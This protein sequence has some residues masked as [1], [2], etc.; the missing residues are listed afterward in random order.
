MA[1]ARAALFAALITAVAVTLLLAFR[2]ADTLELPARDLVLRTLPSRDATA[3]TVVA[4]DEPSLQKLGPWP[5]RREAIAQLVDHAAA[6]GA[7][8]A[9]LDILLADPAPGDDRLAAAL[10][11]LPS[12]AV[13]GMDVAEWRLPVPPL[14]AAAETAHGNFE[15]DHDGIARRIASTKQSRTQALTALS[16]EAASIVTAR[17]VP[18]GVSIAPMF[19]TRPRAIPIVSA[20]QLLQA[21][22]PR[23][24][25]KL[26]FLGPTA[27][28]LGDRV[29]TP[30]SAQPDPGVTVHAAAT[31]SLI[32]GDVV[33][34]V[35][36]IGSAL[37]SGAA[38]ASILLA[39]RP[40]LMSAA[41]AIVVMGGGTLLLAITGIAIPFITL[42]VTALFAIAGVETVR[43]ANALRQSHA[44]VE[45]LTEDRAQQVESKRV[46]AHELK[47]PL[48]SMRG[49]SQLLA[50]FDLNDAERRRVATLLES[51]AGKLQSMVTGLLDLER[52]STRDFESSSSVIDLGDLVAARVEFLRASSDREMDVIRA[53]GLLVRA[54]AALI[55]RV[56]D[57]LVG[58]A[59]KYTPEGSPITV[60]VR[61]EAG[62]AFIEVEDRGTGISEND[63]RRIFDRFFRGSSAAGTQGL[64]LGLSLVAE[65][66]RWHRGSASVHESA[67][68]G[69]LFRFALPLAQPV[70]RAGGM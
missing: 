10:R 52:L 30:V 20:V 49:L 28:G 17:P 6:S 58:N 64:G 22:M 70:A 13:A 1:R 41:I 43:T 67:A 24:R 3:T 62:Q 44:T 15:L 5:W 55:E 42:L 63:R 46:L 33:R 9:I 4:I 54:D 65:A 21:P 51:E 2:I 27:I 37:L 16:I 50:Q 48:A 34:E 23:L 66:A 32:R 11:R 18:V 53:P 19:R 68:G 7:R 29:L 12:I 14:R 36:P 57:N 26:L 35:P 25:G 39:R 38:V 69:A 60:T 31:E 56:L 61:R 8:A 40:R 59:V 45:Q 47:T